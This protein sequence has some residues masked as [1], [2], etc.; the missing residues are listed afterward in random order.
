[1]PVSGLLRCVT[2]FEDLRDDEL[3]ALARRLN[4]RVFARGAFVFEKGALAQY[5]YVIEAGEVRLFA[6]SEAGREMTLEIYGPGECFGE[7]ALL[8]GSVRSA[9][10]V[11]RLTTVAYALER[12]EFLSCLERNPAVARRVMAQLVHRLDHATVY[13]ENLAFLDV[14]QRV[15]TALVELSER[16]ARANEA[17]VLDLHLTQSEL[18]TWCMA[19]REMVNR[20]LRGYRDRGLIDIAGHTILI[21]DPAGLKRETGG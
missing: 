8:D 10:A 1:M 16:H 3:V 15:A 5:L 21:L 9:A 7:S 11:A 20:V 18:A 13:A 17:R 4:R 19:S 2:L 14:A 6:V 12:D